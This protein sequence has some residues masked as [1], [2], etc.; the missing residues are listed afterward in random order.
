MSSADR[1]RVT[2]CITE[3]DPGGAERALVELATRLDRSRF[4]PTVISL[5]P[6]GP[7]ADVLEQHGILTISLGARSRWDWG[8]VDRLRKELK[9]LRPDILQTWLFHANLAGRIAGKLAGVRTILSGIRVAERRS[10][11]P[12]R[13]DR[14]T[15]RWVQ[16]HVCVSA[17]VADFS[18]DVA[19]LPADRIEV[20]PNGVDLDR[21][22]A[23]EPADPTQWGIPKGAPI[24]LTVGRLDIQKGLPFLWDA[25][26][27]VAREY[28]AA[29]WLIVGEGSQR[30]D[31]ET[32][33]RELN[34]TDRVHFAGWRGDIPQILAAGSGLVLPSLW[35]GMP[36]VVL[37]AM[38][39]GL[40]VI[41]T[42]VEGVLELVR[43]GISGWCVPP[44]DSRELAVAMCELLSDPGRASE[45]GYAGRERV[46]REFTWQKMVEQYEALYLRSAAG[47]AR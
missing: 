18:R 6:R 10:R 39:A 23:V 2:F 9:R 16:T 45:L 29:H 17:A 24:L 41:A 33:V 42:R 43:P 19:G 13:I 3:L 22:S 8:I 14:W 20:I 7:L 47:D 38:A 44:R 35:E 26:P 28:T 36:N 46:A 21:F 25:I 15:S 5:A 34:L 27:E 32:R 30:H 11:W 31:S 12:L 40:P 4:D 1:I 37:E